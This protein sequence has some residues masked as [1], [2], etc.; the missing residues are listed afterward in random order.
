[1]KKTIKRC[2]YLSLL[3]SMRKFLFAP[4]LAVILL[5]TGCLNNDKYFEKYSA[6]VKA[7]EPYPVLIQTSLYATDEHMIDVTTQRELVEKHIRNRR[8]KIGNLKVTSS[9]TE[10]TIFS[11]SRNT[12]VQMFSNLY[13]FIGVDRQSADIVYVNFNRG[14]TNET[15]YLGDNE[16]SISECKEIA[17]SFLES[18]NFRFDPNEYIYAEENNTT[19]DHI[20]GYTFIYEKKIDTL[21]TSDNIYIVVSKGGTILELT[22]GDRIDTAKI[23]ELQIDYQR[24]ED[25]IHTFLKEVA[26]ITYPYTLDKPRFIVLPDGTYALEYFVKFGET[27]GEMFI[28]I[29]LE[30][31]GIY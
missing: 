11:S 27:F 5:V 9:Y 31:G 17:L 29:P 20:D 22:S 4:M 24:A 2:K 30:D 19:F 15:L 8:D 26:N 13:G 12:P 18:I 1:M 21:S 16:L 6:E 23:T 28:M 7:Y 3:L 10:T 14:I 25:S